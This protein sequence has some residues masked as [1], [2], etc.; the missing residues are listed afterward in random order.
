MPESG[1]SASETHAAWTGF[2]EAAREIAERAKNLS[3]FARR[4]SGEEKAKLVDST[5]R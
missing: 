4:V 3:R 1:E 5:A 2:L